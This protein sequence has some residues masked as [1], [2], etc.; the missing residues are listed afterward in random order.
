MKKEM[1]KEIILNFVKRDIAKK[2]K[3]SWRNGQFGTKKREEKKIQKKRT[4]PS[5]WLGEKE[6][7]DWS[8]FLFFFFPP[9]ITKHA[10][11]LL[12]AAGCCWLLAAAAHCQ[13]RCMGPILSH[14][15]PA[16]EQP[17][18][19]GVAAPTKIICIERYGIEEKQVN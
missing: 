5:D 8:I 6:R 2:G 18:A 19:S 14:C 9:K 4:E 16:S 12:A 11:R 17:P 10:S 7:S 13:E 15:K 1:K 3:W